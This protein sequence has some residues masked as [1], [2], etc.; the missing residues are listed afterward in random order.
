MDVTR[1]VCGI[2][3]AVAAI[4]AVAATPLND[5]PGTTEIYSAEETD[6]AITAAT[7]SIAVTAADFTP[8][9]AV[10]VATI[11]EV[12]PPPGNY[13]TVSNRAMGAVQSLQPAYEYSDAAVVDLARTN[14]VLNGGP[15]LKTSF[16]EGGETVTVGYDVSPAG[17]AF[18]PSRLYSESAYF[19][20]MYIATDDANGP[21]SGIGQYGGSQRSARAEMVDYVADALSGIELD[22]ITDGTNEIDA[23]GNVYTNGVV[24]GRIALTN[25]IPAAISSDLTP[26]TN[27]TDKVGE[28]VAV[29]ATNYTDAVASDIR[30]DYIPIN[31]AA[32]T[33]VELFLNQ[34]LHEQRQLR[35]ELPGGGDGVDA[36][37]FVSSSQITNQGAVAAATALAARKQDVLPYFTNAIPFSVIVGAP[38]LSGQTFDFSRNYDIIR[39]T[40]AIAEALGA[41]VTNNPTAQGGN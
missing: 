32:V 4:A 8:S 37:S 27:Y 6:A 20:S 10:L 12:A 38:S 21:M 26:A 13:E 17:Y 7:N 31:G 40:A 5:I 22:R 41:T 23:A 25:D 11:E 29:D 1:L 36:E 15:Y 18:A 3:A 30:Q 9:N 35:L 33:D 28:R 16:S 19:S 34:P 2:V 14:A 24:A 39:A